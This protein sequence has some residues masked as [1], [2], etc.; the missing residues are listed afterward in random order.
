VVPTVYVTPVRKVLPVLVMS[1]LPTPETATHTRSGAHPFV[2]AYVTEKVKTV[3]V[4]PDAGLALP[5]P[6]DGV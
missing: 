1:M 3:A 4:V 6:R 5:E 2:S